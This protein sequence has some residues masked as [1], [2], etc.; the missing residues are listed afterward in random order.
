M[1]SRFSIKANCCLL[2]CEEISQCSD[3]QSSKGG[4]W[5]AGNG[6]RHGPLTVVWASGC[7]FFF[8]FSSY[9][10]H[11]FLFLP[12]WMVFLFLLLNICLLCCLAF[13]KNQL[14]N[15]NNKKK[16]PPSHNNF[17][18]YSL[19]GSVWCGLLW[20]SPVKKKCPTNSGWPFISQRFHQMSLMP[21][22]SHW[23]LI[24][25]LFYSRWSSFSSLFLKLLQPL[26]RRTWGQLLSSSSKEIHHVALDLLFFGFG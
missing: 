15:N 21:L 3:R 16:K 8:L 20:N 24:S 7:F 17:Y 12:F 2:S 26:S 25:M 6:H 4:C 1:G 22:S 13:N 19:L 18:A 23:L 9:G 10:C 14:H 11:L 5:K